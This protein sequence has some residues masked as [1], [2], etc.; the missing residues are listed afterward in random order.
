MVG[1][2]CP[3]SSMKINYRIKIRLPPV[4]L[5]G[6]TMIFLEKYPILSVAVPMGW[7]FL[8]FW[9]YPAMAFVL[10]HHSWIQYFYFFKISD[11]FFTMCFLTFSQKTPAKNSSDQ[12]W[13]FR[14]IRIVY[15]K[16]Q[17]QIVP[18]YVIYQFCESWIFYYMRKVILTTSAKYSSLW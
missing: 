16:L 14:M 17:F 3:H 18:N 9:I 11:E 10:L 4:G 2:P 15:G 5:L 6:A 13:I 7:Y 12:F 8:F 1:T